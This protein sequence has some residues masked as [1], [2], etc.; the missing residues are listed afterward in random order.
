M[1]YKVTTVH[2]MVGMGRENSYICLG[3]MIG[4]TWQEYIFTIAFNELMNNGSDS[5]D[6]I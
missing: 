3:G 2:L 4:D 5:Y 1:H 6:P